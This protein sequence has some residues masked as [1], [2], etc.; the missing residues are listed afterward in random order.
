MMQKYG[1]VFA[2]RGLVPEACSSWF[3]PRIVGVSKALEWIY[4]GK[5]FG[6]EELEG[7]LV[8]SEFIN[9]RNYYQQQ[10]RLLEIIDNTAP[11]SVALSRQMIWRMAGANHQWMHIKLIVE[12]FLPEEE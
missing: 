8:K 3:L 4:S 6:P 9:Q 7:G 5:V 12:E 2:R 10:E 1:F 11:V